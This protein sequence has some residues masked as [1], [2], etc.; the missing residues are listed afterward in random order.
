M[1]PGRPKQSDQNHPRCHYKCKC[2]DNAH[3][4]TQP[5]R[6]ATPRRED[7]FVPSL[8]PTTIQPSEIL[9]ERFCLHNPRRATISE[10]RARFF[11]LFWNR[12]QHAPCDDPSRIRVG[13]GWPACGWRVDAPRALRGR[14]AIPRARR[15]SVGRSCVACPG[16]PCGISA[17]I[18]YRKGR[19]CG[20]AIAGGKGNGKGKVR[21][22]AA[23]GVP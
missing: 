6:N 5:P 16:R 21:S 23:S 4:G 12:M 17:K 22:A 14:A 1:C 10:K 3:R 8:V 9:H 18:A 2:E 20:S 7:G 13:P 15:R 11:F 19:Q